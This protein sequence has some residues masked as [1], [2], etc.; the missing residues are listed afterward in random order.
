[1]TDKMKLAL[2]KKALETLDIEI[3]S[4]ECA[5]AEMAINDYPTNA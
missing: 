2:F 4:T 3:E 5:L 1:M